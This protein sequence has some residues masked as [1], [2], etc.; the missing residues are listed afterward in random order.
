MAAAD[1]FARLVTHHFGAPQLLFYN[2]SCMHKLRITPSS[3]LML[4]LML[5]LLLLLLLLKPADSLSPGLQRPNAN[6][7]RLCCCCL[8][9]CARAPPA[10]ARLRAC[11]LL[12]HVCLAEAW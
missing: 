6:M 11:A 10:H 12:K 2:W 1:A 5:M 7:K 9:T 3:M 4:M 8:N